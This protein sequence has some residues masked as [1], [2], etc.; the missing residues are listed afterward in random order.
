MSIL[1][2]FY[3]GNITPYD[4]LMS[5]K[6]MGKQQEVVLYEEKIREK[7]GNYKDTAKLLFDFSKTTAEINAIT[8]EENFIY[9]FE[10]GIRFMIEA[11]GVLA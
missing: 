10:I 2:E 7:L 6:L 5:K 9:G 8:A 1:K 3:H 4:R 11:L